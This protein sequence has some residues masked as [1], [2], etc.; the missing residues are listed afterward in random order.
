M[1]AF[2]LVGLAGVLTVAVLTNR[3][4]TLEVRGFML[5]GGMTD[6]GLLARD[7]AAYYRG[8]GGW[9]G[10][11]AILGSLRL[12]RGWMPHG[13]MMGGMMA[14]TIHLLAPDGSLIAASG[15][16]GVPLP[17][18]LGASDGEPIVVD[19][20]TI[21]VLHVDTGGDPPLEADLLRRV[22]R[23]I[24][25]AALAAAAAAILVG[26]A[27]SAGVLRPVGELT[28]AARA[29]AR[30]QLSRRVP[31]RGG[32]EIAQLAG[33]FNRMAESLENAERLRQDMT[34]DIAH[35]LRNPLAILQAQVEALVDGIQSPTPETLGPIL[36]QTQLLTRLVEDL[37]TLALADAGQ[38]RLEWTHVDL[39]ALA[40][41]VVQAHQAQAEAGGIQLLY[42]GQPVGVRGDPLRLEQ[43][44]GNL[45]TNALR[46]TPR[47]GRVEVGVEAEA[48]RDL[49]SLMVEDNGKGVPEESLSLI[50]ERFYRAD[51]SRARSGGGAGL[52]L[53]ITKQLV[54]AHGGTLRASNR[55]AGGARF[56][57]EIPAWQG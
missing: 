17:L 55:E 4:A 45:I 1:L 35:E 49:V 32:D 33:T 53:A 21:G 51:E 48:G 44:L 14:P 11:E 29:I 31:V 30:G 39:H 22:N 43:A 23:G 24:A 10:V 28:D 46:H 8:R 7:L 18:P 36:Q 16:G 20:Q 25:L 40:G 34:A 56:R 2:S 47:G 9:E 5:R 57:V 15:P 27:L 42:A 26:W 52:G 19:G 13:G 38:L 37:R 54:E 3:T 6:Q 41:R 50:F 12:P